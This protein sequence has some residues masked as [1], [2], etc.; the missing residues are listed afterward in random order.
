[1]RSGERHAESTRLSIIRRRLRKTLAAQGSPKSKWHS[2]VLTAAPANMQV[3][4]LVKL[5]TAE[6]TA[7]H[8]SGG[9]A[10]RA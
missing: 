7:S 2:F 6:S 4:E 9:S 8:S 3:A 10:N 1:M 5:V